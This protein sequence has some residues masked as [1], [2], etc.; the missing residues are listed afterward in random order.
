MENVQDQSRRQLPR[1]LLPWRGL[2]E[3]LL[4]PGLNNVEIF[5]QKASLSSRLCPSDY[6]GLRPIPGLCSM[7]AECYKV[8]LNSVP[9]V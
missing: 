8:C 9:V 6:T 5:F 4:Q 3:I 1:W 2:L 7:F